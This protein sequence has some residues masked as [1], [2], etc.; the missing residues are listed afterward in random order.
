MIIDGLEYPVDVAL[1][2]RVATYGG[3]YPFVNNNPDNYYDQT[4]LR[5]YNPVE[6]KHYYL[7]AVNAEV[8]DSNLIWIDTTAFI[9][10][11]PELAYALSCGK[12][13]EPTEGMF[14]RVKVES[15]SESGYC[16]LEIRPNQFSRW[17]SKNCLYKIN[18]IL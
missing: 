10:S 14:L 11:Y 3:K 5:V 18:Y 2:E 13:G 8:G 12:R 4:N 9:R 7:E 17:W 15:I 6:K 1:Y 16:N